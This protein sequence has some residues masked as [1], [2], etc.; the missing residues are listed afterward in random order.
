[1]AYKNYVDERVSTKVSSQFRR[2]VGGR[3]E[4]SELRNGAE[5]RH[6]SGDNCTNGATGAA[7]NATAGVRIPLIAA[8]E[9]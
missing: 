4:I 2:V 1:M 6:T 8:W 7:S 9:R 5:P 3:T